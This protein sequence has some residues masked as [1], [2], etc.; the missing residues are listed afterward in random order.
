MDEG[1]KKITAAAATSHKQIL[2]IRPGTK[3][4]RL[5][6]VLMTTFKAARAKRYSVDFNW[7][8]SKA[9]ITHRELTGDANATVRKA[10]H[11]SLLEKAHCKNADTSKEQE[12]IEREL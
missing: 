6:T 1:Q 12:D 5:F 9:R 11:H 8:W 4:N 7:L 3:Y 10:C 2:K